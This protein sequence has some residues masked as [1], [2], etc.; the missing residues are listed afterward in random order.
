M[1][2]CFEIRESVQ[3]VAHTPCSLAVESILSMPEL[4]EPLNPQEGILPFPFELLFG[5]DA[6]GNQDMTWSL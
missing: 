1:S 5:N 3:N 2:F 4:P 6:L